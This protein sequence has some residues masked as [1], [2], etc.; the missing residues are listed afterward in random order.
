MTSN[1]ERKVDMLQV[2]GG[3]LDILSCRNEAMHAGE[4]KVR[5][6]MLVHHIHNHNQLHVHIIYELC[7]FRRVKWELI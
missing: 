3:R 6:Y 2:F 5:C 4:V 7:R 1:Y